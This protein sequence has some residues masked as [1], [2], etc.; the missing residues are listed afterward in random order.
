[1]MHYTPLDPSRREIRLIELLPRATNNA[2]QSEEAPRC[3]LFHV[4]LDETLG[5]A[6]LSYRWGDSRDTQTIMIGHSSIRVTRNLYSALVHLR[7]EKTARHMWIDALC[8]NQSDSK[9]KS[10]QVQLMR[11]IY[12]RATF[13]SIW[14]GPADTTSDKAMDFLH[15]LGTKAM[16]FG[17]DR[18]SEVLENVLTQWKKLASD[19]PS[20]RD[21]DIQRVIM[22]SSD[23]TKID[24]DFVIGDLNELYY[25]ISGFHEKDGLLPVEEIADLFTRSWWSRTWVLQEIS[26]AQKAGFVCGTKCLSR[27]RCTAALVAFNALRSVLQDKLIYSKATLTPYQSSVAKADLNDRPSIMLGMWYVQKYKPLPLIALLRATCSR[28]TQSPIPSTA[29]HLEATDPRDKIYGLLGLAAD[30]DELKKF[31]LQPDYNQSCQDVY[32]S[33]TAAMLK[34][35]QLSVLS[36]SQFPKALTGLPSWV[37]DWSEPLRSPLQNTGP[38][39]VTLEPR[40]NASGSLTQTDFVFNSSGATMTMSAS[41]FVYDKI[42]Y[43]GTTWAEFYLLRAPKYSPFVPAKRLLAELV[44]LSFLR[45]ELYKNIKERIC[46]ASRTVIADLGFNDNGSW[47]RIG[48]H[49]YHTAASFLM[50]CTNDPNETMLLEAG[51][52]KLIKSEG[53]ELEIDTPIANKYIGEIEA[54]ARSRK[55][56]VTANGHLGLGPDYVEPEDVI[57]VLA[58]CQVPLVLRKSVNERYELVGEAYVDRIMD[59]EAV[60]ERQNMGAIELC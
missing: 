49:R 15:S 40:Y 12:Q 51:L 52:P 42:D 58:G 6:A 3:N 53:I 25:S 45:G 21:K 41:G 7:N 48:N 13:V 44:R 24:L 8:I 11:E 35:G 10:W 9:E 30:S 47:K 36:L 5:Y 1:M 31:G 22:K 16:R 20:Y 28:G 19:P 26:L 33:V 57:A 38:D 50:I 54:K 2:P 43:I 17:L 55:P 4:S 32:T 18:G 34:Q 39:H 46:A 60:V 23:N 59:G 37:P 56:F 14:L 27:G 29:H